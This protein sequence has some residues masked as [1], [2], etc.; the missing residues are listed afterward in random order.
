MYSHVS[1]EVARLR[2]AE[3]AELALVRLLTGVN[4]KVLCQRTR[5]GKSFFAHATSA[6]EGEER[7]NEGI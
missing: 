4:A 7:E 1:V 3:V 2:E 6:K 5:V